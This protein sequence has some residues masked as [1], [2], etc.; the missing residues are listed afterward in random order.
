MA[1]QGTLTRAVIRHS[2][3]ALLVLLIALPVLAQDQATSA[4]AAK[5]AKIQATSD[6]LGFGSTAADSL[7]EIPRIIEPI[8]DRKSVV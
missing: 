4:A 3:L 8:K 1:R 6:S 7:Q 2:L 5:F